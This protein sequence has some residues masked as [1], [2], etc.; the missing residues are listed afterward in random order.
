MVATLR[1]CRYFAAA[2]DPC[3][4]T[5]K[6]RGPKS[7]CSKKCERRLINERKRGYNKTKA[8]KRP[9]LTCDT[10]GC[11][12]QFPAYKSSKFCPKHRG[13]YYQ[14]HH[15]QKRNI[16]ALEV[17]W[18]D[19]KKARAKNNAKVKAQRAKNL[20]HVRSKRR[21]HYHTSLAKNPE[22]IRAQ[23]HASYR[24]RFLKD[25]KKVREKVRA[26]G[27]ANYH[28]HAEKIKEKDRAEYWADLN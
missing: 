27:R 9:L 26:D 23:Q 7:T 3:G 12:E 1:K 10:P 19:P 16:K 4:G 13:D 17:Y 25:P 2:I 8:D 18:K 21:R 15:K 11:E 6:P 24:R 22:K 20:D 5:F 14:L 28:K